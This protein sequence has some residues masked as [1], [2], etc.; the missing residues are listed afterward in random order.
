LKCDTC[1]TR[2]ADIETELRVVALSPLAEHLL[3]TAV[4]PERQSTRMCFACAKFLGD[5]IETNEEDLR[6]LEPWVS[7]WKR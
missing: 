6:K 7:Q 3:S 2:E 1:K 5:I 4:V